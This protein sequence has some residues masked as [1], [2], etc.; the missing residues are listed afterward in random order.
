M[1]ELNLATGINKTATT[2]A[3]PKHEGLVG[4]WSALALDTP[5]PPDP[6]YARAVTIR[7]TEVGRTV[8][9]T[10]HIERL[11]GSVLTPRAWAQV[12]AMCEP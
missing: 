1:V 9:A 6:K 3:C 10:F 7:T 11:F 12:G 5:G 2:L 8:H 4:S